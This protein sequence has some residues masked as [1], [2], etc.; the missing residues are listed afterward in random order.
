MQKK[1]LMITS[2]YDKTCSYLIKKFSQLTFFRLDLDKFSDYHVT[3][4]ADGFKIKDTNQYIDTKTCESIYFRKPSMEKLDGIFDNHYH[5]YIHKETYAFI[6]GIVESFD[7]TVLTKPSVMRRAN[8]KILQASLAA[9][10]GLRL[11]EFAITNDVY[12]LKHFSKNGGIIKPI[13][14]GEIT[15]GSSKEFVQTNMIDPAFE[16]NNFEYSP[17]YLQDYIEKEF[18]VRITVVD[19]QFFPVKINSENNVDWRKPNNKVSY[20]ICSIPITIRSSCLNF[21]ELCNMKFGCFDFIVKNSVWYFL[22]MN[23]N[24]QWAWLEFATKNSISNAI[25]SYLTN[26]STQKEQ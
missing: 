9:Q 24:G 4:S 19:G 14:I 20:E 13:A 22:E 21:M 18:E 7:G 16:A 3:F 17:V 10:A 25:I 5:A 12:L 2:S 1:I 11:P 6:E 23:A 26:C 15:S 8:N